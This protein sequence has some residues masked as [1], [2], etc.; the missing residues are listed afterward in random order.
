MRYAFIEAEKANYPIRVLCRVLAVS[1]SGFYAQ[2]RRAPSRRCGED[3]QLIEVIRA[4]H[5]ASRGTYGSPRL[6]RELR[7][8]GYRVGRHRVARLMRE[9]GLRGCRRRRFKRTARCPTQGHSVAANWLARQFRVAAPN[10]VWAADM[11][12]LWTGEGWLYLAVVLDLYSR[13]V[14]GWSMGKRLNQALAQQ[15]L[16][17]ALA[18]RRVIPGQLLH[19]SDRGV[20]YTSHAYRQRLVA[21]GIIA[22]MSGKGDCWDNAVAESFF[23]TLKIECVRDQPLFSRAQAR[24]A[25]FDYIEVFYNRQRRHSTLGYLSPVDYETIHSNNVH[26][27]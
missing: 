2:R 20:Q 6:Q 9:Q 10:R 19:H 21:H 13:R 27:A 16:D 12:Y 17:M 22:S 1:R 25:L 14:V 4:A 3:R 11:T 15:A 24:S 18:N 5:Q 26:C 23:A 8:Q 7:A